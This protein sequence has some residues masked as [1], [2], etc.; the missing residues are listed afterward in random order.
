MLNFSPGPQ[1]EGRIVFDLI[2]TYQ[3]HF[4]KL[5]RIDRSFFDKQKRYI[6]QKG[7]NAQIK[8]PDHVMYNPDSLNYTDHYS[9]MWSIAKTI[10]YP[11]EDKCM[12]IP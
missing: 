7:D 4:Y 8:I 5:R 11:E 2:T 12:L 3:Q 1:F 10:N 6:Y 9:I